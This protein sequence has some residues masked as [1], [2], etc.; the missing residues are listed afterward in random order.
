MWRFA[1]EMKLFINWTYNCPFIPNFPFL[2]PNNLNN[3]SR[4]LLSHLFGGE[5]QE[6]AIKMPTVYFLVHGFSDKPLARSGSIW[7]NARWSIFGKRLCWFSEQMGGNLM[8]EQKTSVMLPRM[9]WR[10]ESGEGNHGS[11]NCQVVVLWLHGDGRVSTAVHW[12]ADVPME[13]GIEQ[14]PIL[15]KPLKA[16]IC[17]V[18]LTRASNEGQYQ[19]GMLS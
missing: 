6:K 1:N 5:S 15:D 3:L 4:C 8:S 14:T 18:V 19:T 17:F 2:S 7:R 10:L 12:R 11:Q 9:G 16:Q 13:E